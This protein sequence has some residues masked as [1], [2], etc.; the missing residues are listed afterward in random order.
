[1]EKVPVLD[2]GELPLCTM[3]SD[4]QALDAWRFSHGDQN[5]QTRT[6]F[7][8]LALKCTEESSEDF[9]LNGGLKDTQLLNDLQPDGVCG[10]SNTLPESTVFAEARKYYLKFQSER[11]LCGIQH[12]TLAQLKGFSFAETKKILYSSPDQSISAF[13]KLL[14]PEKSMIKISPLK[15]KNYSIKDYENTQKS[16]RAML[17]G[18]PAQPA[19]I[20]YCANIL[21]KKP[22]FIGVNESKNRYE[23]ADRSGIAKHDSNVKCSGHQSLLI[24]R[25]SVGKKCQYLIRNSWGTTCTPYHSNWDCEGGNVWV[26]ESVLVKNTFKLRELEQKQ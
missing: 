24:G 22:D 1:M 19:I 5:F 26:D 21:Q 23:K 14:C 4:A 7:S 12:S 20:G 3:A 8:Y 15:F 16:L 11:N 13:S 2:Q 9:Y 10:I 18:Q 17:R 6:S 25:R